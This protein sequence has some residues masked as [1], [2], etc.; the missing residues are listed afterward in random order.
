MQNT[1]DVHKV[2]SDYFK[3]S[4]IQAAAYAVSKKLSEGH[5]CL[6]ID[7]Y[8]QELLDN[9]E[10]LEENP[11]LEEGDQLHLEDLNGSKFVSDSLENVK[12]FVL[13]GN[14]LY[15]HKY[16]QYESAILNKIAKFLETEDGSQED[17]IKALE[18][19]KEFI[20]KLFDN[21][22]DISLPLA[23][24]VNWQLVAAMT[25]ILKQF[26]IITGGPGTGKTTAV[27]KILAVLY[28][29][30]PN[31]R[32][33]LAAPTGK[34][35]ARMMESLKGAKEGISG[36]SKD[37]KD[38]Y[39]NIESGTLHR[40]L[41]YIKGT[42]YFKHNAENQLDFDVVIV[43]ESSM[44]AVGMM[45]KLLDAVKAS[46]KIIF[47]GDK[48]QLASVEAG[49]VFGDICISQKECMNMF[50]PDKINFYN[51]FMKNPIGEMGED[52]INRE[53]SSNLLSEHVVE[54]KRSYRFKGDQ[55]IG[56]F[57]RKT[58]NGTL[59]E[60]DFEI[61]TDPDIESVTV[62]N[63][64]EAPELYQCI[65]LYEEYIKEDDIKVALDKLNNIRFLCSVRDGKFGVNTYNE[66][67]EKHLA[68]KGLLTLSSGIYHNQ[69]IIVSRNDYTLGL[70]N[71]DIG[72]IRKDDH[73]NYKAYFE[74]PDGGIKAVLPG[75]ISS[76][77]TVFAMTIHKSQ[78]SEFK[79]TVVVVSDD[80]NSTILT[81]ELVYTG[82]TR[83]K[84]KVIVFGKE[85]VIIAAAKRRVER[86]SGITER[87]LNS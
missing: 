14:K 20:I 60:N 61:E 27:A 7:N 6:N 40:L 22:T 77:E 29:I 42:H 78:G 9:P 25:S 3:N 21:D 65:E 11:H 32:V 76:F 34:A 38:K 19:H 10:A 81:S 85:E 33:V 74:N 82:I 18:Q 31:L 41:G 87:I 15:I 47:L 80:T 71:G 56:K 17:I 58:I 2:F 4:D 44:I 43:D 51:S 69:P 55:G 49:S 28:T 13:N 83:G 37:I 16:F 73:D 59:D 72:I 52:F 8:N 79:T 36:L 26:S 48:D 5:I 45:A 70:F 68:S 84:K 1:I 67:I 30:Y 54:L 62:I 46:S 39:D 64:Y 24:R 75:Y 23:E 63:N 86:A 66:R 35:A 57:S 53:H 50:P 12:P